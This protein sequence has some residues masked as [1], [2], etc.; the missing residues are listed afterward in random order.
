MQIENGMKEFA[1]RKLLWL[2]RLEQVPL[3][4]INIQGQTHPLLEWKDSGD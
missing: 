3:I 2:S 1:V 4:P